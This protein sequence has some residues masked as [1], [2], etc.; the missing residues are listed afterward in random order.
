MRRLRRHGP[1]SVRRLAGELS[2][3]Y[4]S[5]HRKTAMLTASGLV[6]RRAKDEVAVNWDH[7]VPEVKLAA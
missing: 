6:E 2:R 5:L 3:D 1:M 7:A 4:K